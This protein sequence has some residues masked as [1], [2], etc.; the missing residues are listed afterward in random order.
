MI[1][2]SEAG[3]QST[4]L[5][6]DFA[7]LEAIYRWCRNGFGDHPLGF[8]DKLRLCA[9]TNQSFELVLMFTEVEE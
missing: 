7:P 3:T 1:E 6:S 9:L 2:R 8:N 5:R 4:V